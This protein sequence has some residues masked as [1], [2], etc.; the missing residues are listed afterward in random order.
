MSSGPGTNRRVP[1]GQVIGGRYLLEERIA[2]GGMGVVWRGRHLGLGTAVAIKLIRP[3]LKEDAECVQ[4]F[5]NE[6]RRA[7]S[8]RSERIARV[9]DVG[10]LESGEPYLVMELLEGIDLG[11]YAEKRG[12]LPRAE[13]VAIV[14]QICEGLAEA[15]AIGVVHR[16]IKPANVFLARRT[17]GQFGVKLL[18]FGISK[19][20]SDPS[21]LTGDDE[22]LGSPWYMSPEQMMDPS[23]VDQRSDIW[24]VGVVLFELLTGARPFE[25]QNVPELCA[26]VLTAPAPSLRTWIPDA[27]PALEQLI[28]KCLAKHPDDRFH[29][30]TALGTALQDFAAPTSGR[31]SR[32]TPTDFFAAEVNEL[33]EPRAEAEFFARGP[34]RFDT[35][36][37]STP[38]LSGPTTPPSPTLMRRVH[39]AHT[40]GAL[41]VIGVLTL[42]GFAAVRSA[43]DPALLA[44]TGLKTAAARMPSVGTRVKGALAGIGPSPRLAVGPEPLPLD[45][46]NEP[47]PLVVARTAPVAD[48]GPSTDA[49]EADADATD[50]EGDASAADST[51]AAPEK[52]V[53][54]PRISPEEVRARL[55]RYEA[56]LKEQGL[57]RVNQGT[58]V[59]PSFMTEP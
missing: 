6:A 21:A 31:R 26:K 27:D 53:A 19:Q 36:F 56:W 41:G 38:P 37:D 9:H 59:P 16:D 22:S 40:L 13:A 55:E 49:D 1:P 51:V 54:A 34:A 39:R 47:L 18:D 5:L 12:P 8:L 30:V 33:P 29:D 15:H 48:S 46:G 50:A 25:G 35:R 57:V 58:E 42:L 52:R 44:G 4:R 11:E 32:V 17:D 45:R 23:R 14:Q 2:E 43:E 7:A 28:Q 24:S 20:F 10:Q 3:D